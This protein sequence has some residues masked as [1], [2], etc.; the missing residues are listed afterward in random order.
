M[1]DNAGE[2][3]RI[4]REMT[5]L[6]SRAEKNINQLR[7]PHTHEGLLTDLSNQ[8]RRMREA[9]NDRNTGAG[10]R[11]MDDLY[12]RVHNINGVIGQLT[13]HARRAKPYDVQFY[14]ELEKTIDSF[15]QDLGASESEIEE[16]RNELIRLEEEPAAATPAEVSPAPADDEEEG[17][18]AQADEGIGVCPAP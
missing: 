5:G 11:I 2:Q 3:E 6:K 14:N 18:E 1:T 16:M 9:L 13:G 10:R 17:E 7:D 15:T 12:A 8:V 4:A